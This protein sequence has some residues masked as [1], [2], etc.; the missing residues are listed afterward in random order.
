[1]S[2]SS[3]SAGKYNGCLTSNAPGLELFLDPGV[4]AGVFRLTVLSL[5][6]SLLADGGLSAYWQSSFLNVQVRHDGR[7]SSHLTFLVLQLRQPAR[8]LRCGRFE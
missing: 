4:V 6:D 5:S 2:V 3:F 7:A 8:D 1:M